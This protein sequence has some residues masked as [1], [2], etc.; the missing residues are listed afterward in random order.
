MRVQ[1]MKRCGLIGRE[2]EPDLTGRSV[3]FI[4]GI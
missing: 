4:E 1:N 2:K 3:N